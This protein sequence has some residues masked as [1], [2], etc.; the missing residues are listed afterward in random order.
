MKKS[1][2]FKPNIGSVNNNQNAY[3]SFLEKD[4]TRVNNSSSK[5]E[6][7]NSFINKLS[8]KGEY[9]FSKQVIIETNDKTYDTKIAGKMGNRI[10]TLDGDTI[11]IDDIKSVSEK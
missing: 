10:V 7:V 8:S 2:I 6:D 4:E 3:Y 5:K 11:N 9:I 1:D